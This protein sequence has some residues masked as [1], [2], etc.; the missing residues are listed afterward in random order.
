MENV[1]LQPCSAGPG[2][3]RPI[4]GLHTQLSANRGKPEAQCT[5]SS[6]E[7]ICTG[8]ERPAGGNREREL[9]LVFTGRIEELSLVQL[10]S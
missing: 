7:V 1:L 8:P 2:P 4:K 6:C 10:G 5:D 3:C 9:L